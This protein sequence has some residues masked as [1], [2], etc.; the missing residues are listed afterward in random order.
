MR[1]RFAQ[2]APVIVIKL[3]TSTNIFTRR[4]MFLGRKQ[5]RALS[6]TSKPRLNGIVEMAN[7][8]FECA[9]R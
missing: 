1:L 4:V 2:P 6:W 8:R 5:T 3:F 9:Q 7:T